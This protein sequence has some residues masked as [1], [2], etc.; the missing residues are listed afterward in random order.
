[1]LMAVLM[2]CCLTVETTFAQVKG[3]LNGKVITQTTSTK[4]KTPATKTDMVFKDSKGK[5]YPVWKTANGKYYIIRTSAKTGKEYKQYIT[6][7]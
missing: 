4:S 6:I 3:K 1:M 5:E 2:L 7:E